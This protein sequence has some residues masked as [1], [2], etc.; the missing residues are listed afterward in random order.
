MKKNTFI[1]FLALATT[2]PL[3]GISNASAQVG[4]GEG[5]DL[6]YHYIYYSDASKTVTIGYQMEYCMNS[7]FI[8][9]YPVS[10][11][12]SLHYDRYPIGH[13]PGPGDW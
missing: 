7:Q 13:C 11:E 3:T 12:S 4:P 2:L 9:I 8:A 6:Y 10:G 5:G 1:A